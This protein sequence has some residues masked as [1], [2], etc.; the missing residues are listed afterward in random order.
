LTYY[1]K[2]E[3][4]HEDEIPP[5]II[6]LRSIIARAKGKILIQAGGIIDEVSVELTR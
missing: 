1:Y 6:W 3:G 4:V 5:E 2:P